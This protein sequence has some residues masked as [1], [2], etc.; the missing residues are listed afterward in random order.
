MD[1]PVRFTVENSIMDYVPI[2]LGQNLIVILLRNCM[3]TVS[4][5]IKLSSSLGYEMDYG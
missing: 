2:Q 4:K 1:C 5:K 3:N